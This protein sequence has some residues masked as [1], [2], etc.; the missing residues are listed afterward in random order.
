MN[1]YLVALTCLLGS[2]GAYANSTVPT[3]FPNCTEENIDYFSYLEDRH[4]AVELCRIDNGWRFTYGAIDNVKD[5]V[6]F[7]VSKSDLA[8]VEWKDENGIM[9]LNYAIM[10]D[11]EGVARLRVNSETEPYGTW[12]SV[13]PLDSG[14]WGYVN[15][16]Y[17]AEVPCAH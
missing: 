17:Y 12:V 3:H 2:T 13:Q 11:A 6:T 15:K 9:V 1:R 8:E 14:W 16:L 4:R 10:T 5:A 7:T